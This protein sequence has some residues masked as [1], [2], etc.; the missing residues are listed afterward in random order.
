[1]SNFTPVAF[2]ISVTILVPS[3]SPLTVSQAHESTS[4]IISYTLSMSETSSTTSPSAP[5]LHVT[6][7]IVEAPDN[8]HPMITKA[9]SGIHKPKVFT[10]TKHHLL[11]SVDPLTKIPSAPITYLQ[12]SKHAPWM[13]AMQAKFQALQSTNTSDLV[14]HHPFYNLVGCK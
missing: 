3:T 8:T 9:K 11:S 7:S 4:A 14:P 12:A 10:A 1:M 13:I 6:N 5:S 2:S